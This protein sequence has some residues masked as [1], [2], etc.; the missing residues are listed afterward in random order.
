[1][2]RENPEYPEKNLSEQSREPSDSIHIWRRVLESNPGNIGG[3]Q[4]VSPLRQ[5]YSLKGHGGDCR[6]IADNFGKKFENSYHLS[7]MY[8]TYPVSSWQWY[9][10]L[11]FTLFTKLM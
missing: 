5:P 4:A 1:M 9:S 6:N 10:L 3:R 11:E 7:Y 8:V 2:E